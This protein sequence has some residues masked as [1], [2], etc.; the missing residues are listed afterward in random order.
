MLCLIVPLASCSSPDPVLYTIGIQEGPVV[1]GTPKNIELRDIGL[2]GYLDR[3]HVVLSSEGYRL[4]VMANDTWGEP[5]AGMIARVLSVELAQRL[6]SSNVYSARSGISVTADAVIEVNIQRMDVGADGAL[7][8][9]AQ[10]AV[11]F[12][13]RPQPVARTFTINKPLAAVTT[14]DEVAAISAAIAQLAD[15]LAVMLRP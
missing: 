11:K 1:T 8:L 6:P 3:P 15:G 10:A 5:L 2:A 9:L 13:N 12:R 4:A 7:T 14:G